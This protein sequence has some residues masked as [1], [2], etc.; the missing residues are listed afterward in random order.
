MKRIEL[1]KKAV[2]AVPKSEW[3]VVPDVHPAIITDEQFKRVREIMSANIKWKNHKPPNKNNLFYR[4]IFCG[5]CRL[6]LERNKKVDKCNYR[7]TTKSVKS[8]LTCMKGSISEN[9]IIEAVLATIKLQ[10]QLADNIKQLSKSTV[11]SSFTTIKELSGESQ[12][13]KKLI[14]KLKGEKLNLWEKRNDGSLPI[15]SYKYESEKLSNQIAAYTEKIVELEKQIQRLEMEAGQENAFVER[16]S[17]QI[18]INELSREIVDEFIQAIHVYS[19]D[20]IEI[21]LNYIDE[22]EKIKAL[23]GS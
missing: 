7:C 20:R 11:K 21:T 1:G 6:A 15:E 14:E 3:I 8:G 5:H 23:M 19:P 17:T 12:K 10:A 13:L 9:V 22:F 4:K 16:Y 18:F 2:K